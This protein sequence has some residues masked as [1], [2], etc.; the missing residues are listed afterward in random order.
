MDSIIF[1]YKPNKSL[2]VLANIS[3]LIASVMLI[4]FLAQMLI[5]KN[6]DDYYLFG[7]S[8]K[9]YFF[10]MLFLFVIGSYSRYVFWRYKQEKKIKS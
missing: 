7:I 10:I 5:L 3:N 2:S 1:M 8:E 4:I 9:A 6:S